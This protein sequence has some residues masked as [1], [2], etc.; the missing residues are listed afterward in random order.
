[1]SKVNAA[2]FISEEVEKLLP[3]MS[4]SACARRSWPTETFS[5]KPLN[6]GIFKKD[7]KS[8]AL[9]KVAFQPK[10]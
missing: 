6:S 2:F 4:V 8:F 10:N 9:Q 5:S 3:L 7:I 1:M